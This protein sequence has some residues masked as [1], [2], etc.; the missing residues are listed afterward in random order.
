[1]PPDLVDT[2]EMDQF[3]VLSTV[4]ADEA[5]RK[6]G[7]DPAG[8]KF[9]VLY[10]DFDDKEGAFAM[11]EA[12]LQNHRGDADVLNAF[13]WDLVLTDGENEQCFELAMK[14]AMRAVELTQEKNAD[15]LGTV[16][17]LHS[18]KQ[19]FEKALAWQRKAVDHK[20]SSENPERVEQ[21]M[22]RYE[23]ALAKSK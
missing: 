11:G 5:A 14:A 7:A 17:F 12:F 18:E 1:M 13:A 20:E 9:A 21:M 19:E 3:I 2:M 8:K 6:E 15:M 23:S 4:S 16:A 22:K 10:N